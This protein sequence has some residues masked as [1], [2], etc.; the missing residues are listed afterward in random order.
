MLFFSY[1][2]TKKIARGV[3]YRGLHKPPGNNGIGLGACAYEE[4][5]GC[6][7]TVSQ[8]RGTTGDAELTVRFFFF[9]LGRRRGG[10]NFN[11]TEHERHRLGIHSFWVI[12][13]WRMAIDFSEWVWLIFR[14]IIF[15]MKP[16]VFGEV[17]KVS[18]FYQSKRI[19]KVN[20]NFLNH[21]QS[22][23]SL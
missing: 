14:K 4:G 16:N 10:K 1:R 3:G 9:F 8:P 15:L 17:T 6:C 5:G 2:M 13:R 23:I 12:S 11:G 19:F 20:E 22:P 7:I 21:L 18:L